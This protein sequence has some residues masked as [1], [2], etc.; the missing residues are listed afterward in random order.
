GYTYTVQAVDGAGNVG[1]ASNALLATT[2]TS[3]PALFSD[4]WS[5]ADGAPWQSAWTTSGLSTTL[6]TQAGAGRLLVSDVSGA[7]GRAQL[8]GLA[9]RADSE[10]LTSFQWSSNTA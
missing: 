7:Y 9:S 6:D 5:N 4:T 1:P 2:D 3:T 8:T 10:L